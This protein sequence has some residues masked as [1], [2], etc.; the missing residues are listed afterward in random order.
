MK[1]SILDQI[2]ISK[3]SNATEALASS[4]EIAKL[5]DQLGC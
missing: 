3:G 5:G 4:V 1:L 2:P